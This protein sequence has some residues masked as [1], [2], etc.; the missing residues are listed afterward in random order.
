MSENDMIEILFVLSTILLLYIYLGYPLLIALLARILPKP[1]MKD[2]DFRPTVTMVISAFNEEDVLRAKIENSIALEYPKDKIDIVIVSDCSTDKTDEIVRSY[3]SRGVRLIRLEQRMGKTYGLNRALADIHTDIVLFSDANAMYKLDV[4]S[5]MVSHFADPK[6]GYVV[7]RALYEKEGSSSAGKSEHAYWDLE[8][9]LKQWESDFESVVGGDGA[10]YAIRRELYNQLETTDI[11]DFVNPLQIVA[12]GYRGVFEFNAMCTEKTANDFGKE[13]KRKARIV[14]RSFN[15]LLRIKE[16]CNPLISWRFALEV[17]SHKLLRWFSPF[18]LIVQ[19]L[20]ALILN[21]D[22]LIGLMGEMVVG[23]HG[24]MALAAMIG[25]LQDSKNKKG[26]R[27]FYFPYYFY[28][29][30]LA[31]AEGIYKR[32]RGEVIAIWT[33]VREQKTKS[34]QQ[35]GYLFLFFSLTVGVAFYKIIGLFVSFETLNL[36]LSVLL[37]LLI[38]Y[39]FIGY[40][41]VIWL[42]GRLVHLKIDK[43]QTIYPSVT[44]VIPAFNEQCIIRE[45]LENTIKL[46]YPEDRLR[47]LVASDGSSDNTNDIV[48]S[49]ESK[50]IELLYFNKNRGKI[51]I[52]ND[53]MQMIQSEIVIFTDANVM[54]EPSALKMLVRNFKD[55]RVG[56]V[57]GK[58][59]L[60][61]DKLSYGASEQL[62]YSIEYF[63][64]EQ[65]SETGALAGADGAL[66]AIRRDLYLELPTATILDDFVISLNVVNQGYLLV[67]EKEAVGYEQNC[68]ET[69]GELKRKIRIIAGGIQYLLNEKS[70][71]TRKISILGFKI[72]SH[73]ILRWFVGPMV[74]CLSAITIHELSTSGATLWFGI[75]FVGIFGSISLSLCGHWFPELRRKIIF[76]NVLHYL[77]LL[78]LGSLIGCFKGLTDRQKVTWKEDA[79]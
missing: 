73:K 15:G 58:V 2:P 22:G 66:Y 32:I 45:K 9:R 59:Y 57:S 13:F 56:G 35:Y 33:P 23:F 50:G 43:E 40:P 47:V 46:D 41:A 3:E 67:H 70:L 36:Y 38:L 79:V 10:I 25:G 48:R 49:F 26:I 39:T 16:V 60:L 77:F 34:V 18:L 8:L 27:L 55:P 19:F 51:S 31:S 30:M 4:L 53:A 52:I 24:L 5:Y 37:T 74:L 12:S 28:L 62:Y 54:L 63:I 71:P 61:N 6:V 76:I 21:R 65:E 29:V 78:I 1:H 64:Q 11:N 7:G 17:I 20:S 69:D 44:L 14:N 72:F 75:L 42:I 68:N